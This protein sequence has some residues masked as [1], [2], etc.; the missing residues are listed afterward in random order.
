MSRNRE[1]YGF[2]LAQKE[3]IRERQKGI[4]PGCG[5]KCKLTIHHQIPQHFAREHL[6]PTQE[7]KDYIR[8]NGNG[9]G[10]CRQCHDKVE[11]TIG[12]DLEIMKDVIIYVL[13]SEA[14]K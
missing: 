2:S 5:K 14:L 10:L 8:N 9:L 11:E 1:D 13:G 6:K 4:C 12:E 7:V 3:E